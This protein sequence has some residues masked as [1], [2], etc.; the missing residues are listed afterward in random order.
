MATISNPIF[1]Q[2]IIDG[3]GICPG[4]EESPMGPIVRIVQYTNNGNERVWGILY[5]SEALQRLW[6]KYMITSEYLRDPEEVWRHPDIV[7]F[8]DGSAAVYRPE[9]RIPSVEQWGQ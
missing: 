5:E 9:S 4:D 7:T 3:N 6:D 8:Q 2:D 1:I